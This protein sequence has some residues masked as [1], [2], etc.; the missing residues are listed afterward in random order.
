V[1]VT[2]IMLVRDEEDILAVNLK[3][4]LRVVDRIFVLDNG[5]EDSTPRILRRF[6]RRY[7]QVRWSV[8]AGEY[9]QSKML[10]GLAQEAYADGADWVV[11]I[12]AD[13]F[14]RTS[15]AEPLSTWLRGVPSDVGALSVEVVNFVQARWVHERSRRSL[16]TM[17]RRSPAPVGPPESAAGLVAL[18]HTSYVEAAYA[19]KLVLRAGDE[20][21][22]GIGNHHADGI[23][24]R[25][26]TTNEVL[27][28][29]AP[30]RSRENLYRRAAS[31]HRVDNA[32]FGEGTAWQPRR[33]ASL[34]SEE[35]ESEWRANSYSDLTLDV[36]GF[37]H[38]VIV[39]TMLR[40]TVVPY[41]SWFDRATASLAW[42]RQHRSGAT[43]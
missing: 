34:D 19:P 15:S 22:I 4:H 11:S 42:R 8:D 25:V 38:P 18:R 26:A 39:D 43:A 23:R 37:E 35:L 27:C 7:P 21:S 20:L 28:L 24:G 16:L 36:H 12:D 13:E 40:D 14:W 9:L 5:S 2:G 10:T 33:W 17:T 1:L 41:H 32:D 6:A 3:H 29:H 31:G 30:L